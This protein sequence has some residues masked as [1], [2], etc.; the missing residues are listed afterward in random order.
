MFEV[1]IIR[2]CILHAVNLET[3]FHSSAGVRYDP[4]ASRS[5]DRRRPAGRENVI[6]PRAV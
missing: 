6:I 5:D 1:C 2:E 4:G 3:T